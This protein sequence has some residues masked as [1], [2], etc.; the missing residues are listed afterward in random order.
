MQSIMSQNAVYD[1]AFTKGTD[2]N[3]PLRILQTIRQGKIGGGETHLLSLVERLDRKK[4][5]SIVLSFSDGPMIDR[6]KQLG[7]TTHVIPSNKAFDFTVW[8]KV[9]KLIYTEGIDIVHAHGTRAGYRPR[10]L[11]PDAADFGR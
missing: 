8:K 3:R 1:Q 5:E 6:L 9:R 7:I 4:H 2:D 11:L 10:I